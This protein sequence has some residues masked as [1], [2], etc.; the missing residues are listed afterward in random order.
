MRWFGAGKPKAQASSGKSSRML[1]LTHLD[2]EP[3]FV[4]N[5]GDAWLSPARLLRAMSADPEALK[6]FKEL[7][8]AAHEQ[9]AREAQEL[10]GKD[11]PK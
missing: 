8:L 3:D 1:V 6:A 9:A 10:P 5:R 7:E 2:G 4:L 11:L